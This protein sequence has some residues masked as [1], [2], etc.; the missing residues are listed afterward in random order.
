MYIQLFSKNIYSG[1][2]GGGGKKGVGIAYTLFWKSGLER[3]GR[4]ADG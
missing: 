4:G 2:W 3:Y 1:G